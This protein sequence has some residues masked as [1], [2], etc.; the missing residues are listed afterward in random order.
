MTEELVVVN[1]MTPQAWNVICGR[2][3]DEMKEHVARFVTP[4]SRGTPSTV[5]LEGTGTYITRAG[6]RELLTCEHVLERGDVDHRFHGRN[7]V[8]A[9]PGPWRQAAH[10]KDVA[11]T[12]VAETVWNCA[13]HGAGVVPVERFASAHSLADPAELLFFGGYAGENAHYAFGEHAANRSG[14]CSQEKRDTGDAEIFEIFWEPE[15][16]SFT[17]GTS[18]EARVEMRYDD[19]QGFSG[20]LV[21]NTRYLEITSAGREWSPDDAVVTGLLRR[22]DL[23][24]KTLLVWRVE[25]LNGWLANHPPV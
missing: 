14:Y 3:A 9:C 6:A 5:A 4:L 25:H 21:W 7:E 17:P 13:L 23:E 18:T 10:P 8:Y 24:T 11:I 1:A 12:P 22:W 16:T 15:H 19:P 20:S 2:V